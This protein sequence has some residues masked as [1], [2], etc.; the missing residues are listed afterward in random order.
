MNKKVALFS[1]ILLALVLAMPVIAQGPPPAEFDG[2]IVVEGLN[3]PQGLYV[4]SEGALWIVDSGFGGD[5]EV[6]YFDPTTYEVIPGTLGLTANIVRYAEG[7]SEVV[8][9]A[10]SVA[11]GADFLGFARMVEIDGVIYATLGAWH[12]NLGDEVTVPLHGTVVEIVDGEVSA[13][14]DLWAHELAFNPDGTTNIETHPYGITVGNDGLLYVTD[15]AANSL[16]TVD[17][18]TGNVETVA[19]FEGLPG[20]FPNQFRGGEAIMDPVPTNVVVT[21]DDRIFVSYLSGA[22]FVPGTA[23]VVE[24]LADGSVVD[25]AP[26]LT[27]L[28]DLKLG[29]DGNMY[30]VQ[31]G[32]F[33]PE[34]P[35]PNSS[36]IIRILAD[37]SAEV[38]V[39][40]LPFATAIAF[41]A[42]GDAYVAINGIAIPQAGMVL[43]Y[44]GLTDME[45]TPL[46][47]MM[48]PM[49]GGMGEGGQ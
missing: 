16:L 2:E 45:G 44:E 33:T 28:V 13:L 8:A 27:M 22:P 37:G 39:E 21:E 4:D 31:F 20:V 32:Q 42:E 11:V 12:A 38:V 1:S 9:T 30:G 6:E 43:L 24:V 48:P 34:G 10:P 40:G 49:E 36:S 17:P 47:E 23:K 15:A 26:G 5:E 7:E 25:F 14:A 41:T 35:V 18:A 46:A 3:G 19:G 29:P